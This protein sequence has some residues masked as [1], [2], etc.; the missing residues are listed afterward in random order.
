MKHVL[1]VDDSPT[2]LM[3]MASVLERSG[4]GVTK[5][6]SGEEGLTQMRTKPF[7]LVIT[8]Y[9]MPGINGVE[10]IREARRLPN[11]RFTPMLLLTT[12]SEQ[13]KRDDAKAAGATGWLVK[14]VPADKLLQVLKQVIPGA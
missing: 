10:M 13:K 11:A 14:P 9:N 7:A 2:L 8:D 1:L 12:E 3:S 5:A 6:A 4:Y